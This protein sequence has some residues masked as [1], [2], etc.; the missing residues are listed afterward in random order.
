MLA[1]ISTRRLPT[2]SASAPVTGAAAADAYVINPRNMPAATSLPPS[3][4]MRN[5][6]VGKSWKAA[7]K[8]VKLKPH[9]RKKRG[10][11]SLSICVSGLGARGSGLGIRDSGLDLGMLQAYLNPSVYRVPNP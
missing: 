10:V 2:R 11:N 5:G 4:R 3:D 6:A 7:R 1:T 8:T 9:I